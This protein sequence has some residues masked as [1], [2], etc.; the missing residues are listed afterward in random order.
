LDG[1]LNIGEFGN[2]QSEIE[3]AMA[4]AIATALP[5]FQRVWVLWKEKLYG[6]WTA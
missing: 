5:H 6:P 3:A 1:L 2:R 4:P